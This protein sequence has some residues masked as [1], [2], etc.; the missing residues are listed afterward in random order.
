M[1]VKKQSNILQFCSTIAILWLKAFI[2]IALFT[3]SISA[4]LASAEEAFTF[5]FSESKSYPILIS[6]LEKKADKRDINILNQANKECPVFIFIPGILGSKLEIEIPKGSNKFRTI[7]GRLD[8]ET[9]ICDENL[10]SYSPEQKDSLRVSPLLSLEILRKHWNVYGKCFDTIANMQWTGLNHFFQFPYDWRQDNRLSANDLDKVI[11]DWHPH[12]KGRPVIFI[13]HSMGGLVF[14]WWHYNFFLKYKKDYEFKIEQVL[15][16]GTPH[17]GSPATYSAFSEGFNLLSESGSFL[18][19]LEQATITRQ[20][21]NNGPTFPSVFQ[22]L[23]IDEKWTEYTDLNV[24][25]LKKQPINLFAVDIWR[26]L[27]WPRKEILKMTKEEFYDVL[28]DMLESARSFH[29]IL[30][31]GPIIKE[32]LYI[33]SFQHRTPI[34]FKV[35]RQ[36]DGELLQE[37]VAAEKSGDGTVPTDIAKNWDRVQDTMRCKSVSRRHRELVNDEQF[38]E[39]I[40][41]YID[42]G[43]FRRSSKLGY[44]IGKNQKLLNTLAL[45]KIMLPIPVLKYES[46]YINPALIAAANLK[47]FARSNPNIQK[48]DELDEALYF[49][50]RHSKDQNTRIQLYATYCNN[51]YKQFGTVGSYTSPPVRMGWAYNNLGHE[52]T[53]QAK[54]A[55]AKDY[56]DFA[57][58]Y[59]YKIKDKKQKANLLKTTK[60]NLVSVEKAMHLMIYRPIPKK[61]PKS[62]IFNDNGISPKKHKDVIPSTDKPSP[63]F[64]KEQSEIEKNIHYP[65]N[66]SF[67]PKTSTESIQ[68]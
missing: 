38:Y 55:D 22:L 44:E 7:W 19:G 63:K 33:Y 13:A 15:F 49:T 51:K 53:T 4:C 45:N 34:K 42:A 6:S 11:K 5:L 52:L 35:T 29:E 64:Y 65:D 14:K 61:D 59:A 16:L 66:N 68:K 32:A 27:K 40:V 57:A 12:L 67:N 17:Q 54:W 3:I 28:P 60:T 25:S 9:L 10:L 26:R 50:A 41:S 62:N 58:S 8:L 48:P 30:N 21:N 43:R 36:L 23:P 47:I 18:Q 1:L 31:K 24:P 20:L 39:M 2:S 56:F 46:G 37:V